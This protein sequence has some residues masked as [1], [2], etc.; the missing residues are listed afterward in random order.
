MILRALLISLLPWPFLLLFNLFFFH[1]NA[2]EL[3]GLI[4]W[5]YLISLLG[6]LLFPVTRKGFK[7]LG[8]G[9]YGLTKILSLLLLYYL[10]WF[11]TNLGIFSFSSPSLSFSLLLLMMVPHFVVKKDNDL[12]DL[13]AEYSS[14]IIKVELIFF[15]LFS[16]YL[17][18]YALHPELFWGEKPMDFT[19]FNFSLRNND[20]PF[21]DPWFAGRPMKYYYWGYYF[22]SNLA[23]MSGVKG[24]VGYAL[25]LATTAGL[26]G[27]ALYSLCLFLCKKRWLAL[28]G[29]LFIPLASN[30]KAFW[31]I[32]FGEA[33]FDISYFWSTTRIFENKAFAEYPSWSFLFADLHPHVMSYPFVVLMM[34]CLFYG[35]KRVWPQFSWREHRFFFFFHALSFGVLLA[36]NTWDFL[37]YTLFNSLFFFLTTK[38]LRE[39]KVWGL[40]AGVHIVGVLLF[41]PMLLVLQKGTPTQ[42]GP[43]LGKA[44]SLF[45]HFQHHG[46]WWLMAFIMI[47]PVFFLH[48][49]ALRWRVIF[50]SHGFRIFMCSL[51]IGLL[52]EFMVFHDRV[53]TLFKVF[54]NLYL[55]GGLAAMISLRYFKFYLRKNSTIPFALVALLLINASL[56]GTIFT[57]KA[58]TNYRPFG[59]RVSGLKGSEFLKKSNPSDFA[60]IEWIR[61]NVKGTPVLVE[62]YSRSFDHQSTRISMHTGV[63]TYLGWDNHVFL[64]GAKWKD[65]NKRKND[66]D[67]IFNSSDPLKVYEMM[68]EKKLHFLVVGN[69]E[70]KYYSPKGLEKFKQY[71]DIFVPLVQKRGAVLYGVGDYQKY[72]AVVPE[73]HSQS[74]ELNKR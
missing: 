12:V 49:T 53:N 24:E 61:S 74:K 32:V 4:F 57:M 56:L 23:K 33:K 20:L 70:R 7:G 25:S 21:L 6:L 34:T 69:L 30:I 42:W 27:S 37:I 35:L 26:F 22:F 2:L 16:L 1:L 3:S 10:N 46:L 39:K 8:D 9:G 58:V 51:V 52:A 31:S 55:W 43:W 50:Q 71:R 15:A 40:F 47:F 45:S 18:V 65:I 13:I 54:T 72:L 38:G 28:G 44:N 17:C 29:A 11:G 60:I 14:H 66:I 62:R 63:P 19:I 41:F 64:R 36:V 5:Y 68:L 67:Y 59:V 73:N 48:R